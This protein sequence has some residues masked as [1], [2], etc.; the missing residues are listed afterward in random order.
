MARIVSLVAAAA[1][2][3]FLALSIWMARLD[4]SG[5]VHADLMLEGEVP[6]T[7]YLPQVGDRWSALLDPL[8]AEQRPPGIVLMHGFAGDRNA[9]SGLAR[10]VASAGYAVLGIDARG[11]GQNRNPYSAS[12][13]SADTFLPDLRAA[14]DFLRVSPLV[15]GSRIAVMGDS[16]LDAA[17]M[18]SGGWRLHGPY[19]P[20]NALFIYASDDPERIKR[21]SRELAAR[22]AG[23]P[24]VEVGS[25]YGRAERHDA[26]RVVEVPGVNHQ[27]I[28][29]GEEA[30]REIVAWLDVAFRAERAAAPDLADPRAPLVPWLWL[31]LLLLLPG[32]GQLV[33][34][35]VPQASWRGGDGRALG[36]LA[37]AGAF[38]VTLPLL[39]VR[40]P[41]VIVGVEVGDIV[42]S[43]FALTGIALLV[44]IRLRHPELLQ[45]A[46]E[47]PLP[48]LLGAGVGGVAV[49]VLMQPFAAVVHRVTLTP[50][51]SVV[52]AL[53]ALGLF[54]FALAFN[55]LLRRGP[56]AGAALAAVAGRVLILLA[57]WAGVAAGVLGGVVLFMLPT[58]AVVCL[59]FEVL[60]IS[61][62]AASRNHLAIAT[63]DA[64]WLALVLAAVMPIRF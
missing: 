10:R 38:A 22:L 8:P 52:F 32:L 59:L 46:F 24:E 64:S 7:L 20:S 41:G 57:M 18:I 19:R 51:R 62:Y 36:L 48:T 37:L 21:R 60:A 34:Q 50:E 31:S 49:F 63:I 35:L 13:A 58:L 14:V 45:G 26:V 9:L 17:V 53:A 3:L 33:G 40:T 39:A 43:H 29:W 16:G 12:F 23:A 47:R 30:A 55:L 61:L 2:A 56:V 5:P 6:G 54:P 42:V 25:V 44:A 28:I 27:T 11:H 1:F 15:D 4:R